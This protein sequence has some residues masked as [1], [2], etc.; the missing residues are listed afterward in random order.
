M[1]PDRAGDAVAFAV[2]AAPRYGPQR[3]NRTAMPLCLL[4][5]ERRRSGEDE[6]STVCNTRQEI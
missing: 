5:V 3:R 2:D 6:W 1:D 4:R